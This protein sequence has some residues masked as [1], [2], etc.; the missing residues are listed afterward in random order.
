[1]RGLLKQ[2]LCKGL[3]LRSCLG[4]RSKGS[5]TFQL[6]RDK[7][8]LP[9]H[10]DPRE[11]C[12][13]ERDSVFPQCRRAVPWI[14]GCWWTQERAAALCRLPPG[15]V[16][17][18]CP[19]GRH[20][21]GSSWPRELCWASGG[22]AGSLDFL[23][24]LAQCRVPG[25]SIAPGGGVRPGASPGQVQPTSRASAPPRAAPVATSLEI[26]RL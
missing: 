3:G 15:S 13:R 23:L 16:R 26:A 8:Q 25:M 17:L 2:K 24:S 6:S 18:R 11:R 5:S 20:L 19:R 14:P 12:Q 9:W 10:P 1:M 22:T 7:S 4:M 21:E